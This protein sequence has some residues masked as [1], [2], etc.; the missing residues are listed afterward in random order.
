MRD[1]FLQLRKFSRIAETFFEFVPGK[2]NVGLLP[3]NLIQETF[4]DFLCIENVL[5]KQWLTTLTIIDVAD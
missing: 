5:R 4:N 3:F 2:T 1:S